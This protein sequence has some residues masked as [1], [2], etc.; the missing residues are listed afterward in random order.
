MRIAPGR[1]ECRLELRDELMLRAGHPLHG[2]TVVALADSTSALGCLATLPEGMTGFGTGGLT[3]SLVGTASVPDALIC[4][5]TLL[6]GGRT[7]RCGTRW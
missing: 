1:A 3:A 6:H 5:A 7:P 4:V 2:G